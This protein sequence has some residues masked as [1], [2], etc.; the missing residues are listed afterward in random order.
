MRI[1]RWEHFLDAK[2]TKKL[3]IGL[4]QGN[5]KIFNHFSGAQANEKA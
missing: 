4:S 3:E 1:S 2:Q 5:F